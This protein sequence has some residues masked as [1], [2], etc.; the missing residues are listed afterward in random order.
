M[1]S[2]HQALHLTLL[3]IC[4]LVPHYGTW[5]VSAP[6]KVAWGAKAQTSL[7]D[8]MEEVYEQ[9]KRGPQY[10]VPEPNFYEHIW[11]IFDSTWVMSWLNE[12]AKWAH[13]MYQWINFLFIC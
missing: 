1:T 11:D 6:P 9:K 13:G 10:Q 3:L 8:L 12:H 7:W 5:V 4:S 2:F